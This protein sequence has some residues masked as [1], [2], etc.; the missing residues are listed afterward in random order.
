MFSMKI[1][2]NNKKCIF[3][4]FSLEGNFDIGAGDGNGGGQII[5]MITNESQKAFRTK[6]VHPSGT[7]FKQCTTEPFKICSYI[8]KTTESDKRIK[9]NSL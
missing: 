3:H 1:I 9:N 6:I 7:F 8:Q 4:I 5:T 2:K